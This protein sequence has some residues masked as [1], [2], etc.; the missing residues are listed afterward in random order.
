MLPTTTS[1]TSPP[2]TESPQEQDKSWNDLITR[3]KTLILLSFDLRVSQYEED[4]REKDSQRILPG[5]NFCTF[6]ILKEGLARGFESVG[7]V[8]DALLGYDELSVGLDSIVRDQASEGNESQGGSI[9]SYSEDLHERVSEIHKRSQKDDGGRK[10]PQSHIHDAKPINS[11]KKN[12]RDLILSNNISAFDFRCYI[13]ARQMSLLLRLGNAHSV[14]SDLASKLHPRPPGLQRSVSVDDVNLNTNSKHADD[15][16]DLLSLAE[17]CS[18]ALDFITFAG[19]LLREDLI[20]GAKAHE[21][22]F[23]ETLIDNLIQSW[24]FAALQ[25]I[26]EETATSSLPISKFQQDTSTGSS[27]KM[28]PF[29]SHSKEQ[30]LS[31]AEPKTMIHP[32]RSSSLNHGR[33]SSAD[34]PY[35]QTPASGQVI[36]ENGQYHDRPASTQEGANH[37]KTGV[38]ELAGTRAQLHVVQRRI[39]EHVGKSLGWTIGWAA[40]LSSLPEAENLTDVDLNGESA[41]DEEDTPIAKP[42]KITS[43]TAGLSAA[44]IVNA[45]SSVD[46]FRQSYETMSDIIVKHYMAAGQVK[47][48]ESILGDLAALRYELGDYAAAAMYF[49]RMSSSFAEARWNLV[50]S[51][52]LRMYSQC[53]KKLNRKDEYVRTL[54]D[55]LAKSAASR[56]LIR[57]APNRASSSVS[58]NWLD[59]DK[60]DTT[61][62]LSELVEYSEQLPYDRT[63]SLTQYFGD[64]SV[65]PYVRHYD[66][67]DG[68]QLRLQFR[69]V[70]EDDIELNKAKVRLISAIS[71]QAKDIWLESSAAIQLKKGVCR[72]W[73]NSNVGSAQLCYK[74][75]LI[76]AGQHNWPVHG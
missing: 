60:V 13:F 9:L 61:G 63:V 62:V 29:G 2:L 8:E 67:K 68:F 64:V 72:V 23:P 11:R 5:W 31:F 12:Y 17:L 66:D 71:A 6:F 20:N 18:R 19:R 48:G 36:Y 26:L 55:L 4:I 54:L 75:K 76:S 7:L 52:M 59:D 74:K 73:L 1:V 21:S 42:Q 70:L 28:Q 24:T 56:K 69:H 57:T 32:T 40:I 35:A 58:K 37:S 27:G 34:P 22:E 15:S 33:P 10:E 39:L 43:S 16:E 38:Q 47:A 30:K 53:L 51:T 44:A 41:L 3:F 46:H 45:I 65:E 14:R 25:Q 50:E 49:G